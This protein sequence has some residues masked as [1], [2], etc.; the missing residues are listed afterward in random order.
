MVTQLHD[1]DTRITARF[2][3][4]TEAE[5]RLE[6]LGYELTLDEWSR[7]NEY[8]AYWTKDDPSGTHVVKLV[9]RYMVVMEE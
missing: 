9:A 6:A 5:E 3:T 8:R 4:L 2:G 7:D 1:F